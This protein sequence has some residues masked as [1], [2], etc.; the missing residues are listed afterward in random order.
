MVSSEVISDSIAVA[1]RYGNS[2]TVI[3][4]EEVILKIDNQD[5][6][7]QSIER[8]TLRWTQTPHTFRLGDACDMY[9]EAE[10]TGKVNTAATCSLATELG[11]RVFFSKGSPKNLKITT[12]DDLDIFKAL[13]MQESGK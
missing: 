7:H 3:P 2:V 11:R 13:L 4:C 12:K 10:R 8:E 5:S 9:R 6:S 1:E